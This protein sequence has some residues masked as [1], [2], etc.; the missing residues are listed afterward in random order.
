MKPS[1]RALVLLLSALCFA[2]VGCK[3]NAPTIHA[4][5]GFTCPNPPLPTEGVRACEQS[6]AIENQVSFRFAKNGGAFTGEGAFDGALDPDTSAPDPSNCAMRTRA[7]AHFSGKFDPKAPELTGTMTVQFTPI[8]NG[9]PILLQPS[10]SERPF[11]A[12][13]DGA[14]LRGKS[15][16]IFFEATVAPAG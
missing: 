10:N 7:V 12:T 8:E 3:G 5:G 13:F 11:S 9:C 6:H 1:F 4:D 15:G 14:T 16:I 2:S